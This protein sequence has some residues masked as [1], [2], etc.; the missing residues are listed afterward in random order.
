[1]TALWL[2]GAGA[3]ARDAPFD[4]V[5]ALL[6]GIEIVAPQMGEPDPETWGDAIAGALDA[7]PED[8]LLIGHSLGASMLLK[9]IAER[10]PHRPA[11]A[12][13]AFAPPWWGPEGWG[14]ESFHLPQ[15]AAGAFDAVRALRFYHGTADDIV[16]ASHSA[17]YARAFPEA[18]CRLVA[19][20][21]HLFAG[22]ELPE[23]AAELD[24]LGLRP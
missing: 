24:I 11:P 18:L 22:S 15:G 3:G 9:V 1:M 5:S 7:L 10:R 21:D 23:F 4:K 16:D 2:H 8:A 19:G 13:F 20:A 6:G 17:L 14:Q 12:L